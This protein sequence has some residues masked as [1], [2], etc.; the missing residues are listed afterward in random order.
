[1]N[2]A[3]AQITTDATLAGSLIAFRNNQDLEFLDRGRMNEYGARSQQRAVAAAK[4]GRF[5]DEIVPITVTMGVADKASGQLSLREVTLD[6]DE[7]R[8]PDTTLEGVSAIRPARKRSANWSAPSSA[9]PG[10][11]SRTS[12]RSSRPSSP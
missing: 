6:D 9:R 3:V 10:S 5:R 7:G 11:R 8:R 4:E 2:A 1:M 12:P